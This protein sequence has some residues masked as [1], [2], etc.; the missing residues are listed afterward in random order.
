MPDRVFNFAAGF[1]SVVTF[2]TAAL[3]LAWF[4]WRWV[5]RL[6]VLL[7]LA[8]AAVVWIFARDRPEDVGLATPGEPG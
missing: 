8:G 6:P 2:G 3:V 1:S 7:L 4:P 5:L